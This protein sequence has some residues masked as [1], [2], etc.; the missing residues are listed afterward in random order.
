[1]AFFEKIK[2]F[3]SGKQEVEEQPVEDSINESEPEQTQEVQ[4]EVLDK[5]DAEFH[6]PRLICFYC[7]QRIESGKIRFMKAPGQAETGAYHKRCF[8]KLKQG[9]LPGQA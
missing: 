6:K 3:L 8:K 5:F 2:S 1:M 4:E 7:N 9:K